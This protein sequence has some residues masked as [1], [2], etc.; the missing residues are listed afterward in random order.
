M[1]TTPVKDD[2]QDSVELRQGRVAADKE[3]APDHR[4]SSAARVSRQAHLS[5][6]PERP[7]P[8]MTLSGAISLPAL[9]AATAES[10]ESTATESTKSASLAEAVAEAAAA[11]AITKATALTPTTEPIAPTAALETA[12]PVLACATRLLFAVRP[13]RVTPSGLPAARRV[14]AANRCRCSCTRCRWHRHSDCCRRSPYRTCWIGLFSR[15]TSSSA[16]RV[17]SLQDRR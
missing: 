14:T 16:P 10:T 1:L 17:H 5:S 11:E 15:R 12:E 3:S 4:I 8:A 7:K 13:R 9:S 2:L 6:L